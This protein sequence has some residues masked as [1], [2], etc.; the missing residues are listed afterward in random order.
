MLP[1]RERAPGD[2]APPVGQMLFL[3]GVD[4][5]GIVCKVR[6]GSQAPSATLAVPRNSPALLRGRV[7]DGQVAVVT[8]VSTQKRGRMSARNFIERYKVRKGDGSRLR[9]GQSGSGA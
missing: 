7:Q 2:A 6:L 1:P 3:P 9:W 5:K 4:A 8:E